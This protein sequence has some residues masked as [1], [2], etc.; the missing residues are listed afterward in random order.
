MRKWLWRLLGA[1]AVI[2]ELEVKNARL[3][4]KLQDYESSTVAGLVLKGKTLAEKGGFETF[5]V[6]LTAVGS[7]SLTLATPEAKQ[8]NSIRVALKDGD[9]LRLNDQDGRM[10]CDVA[11]SKELPNA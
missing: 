3:A 10:V 1:Q 8:G 11:V 9:R 7:A 5:S 6:D 2:G 4:T